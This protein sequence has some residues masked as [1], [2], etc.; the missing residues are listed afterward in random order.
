[1][2][3]KHQRKIKKINIAYYI[4]KIAPSVSQRN[5]ESNQ[6]S[7]ININ[8]KNTLNFQRNV[9]CTMNASAM[10]NSIIHNN[11]TMSRNETKL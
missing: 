8:K 2:I 1:M 9:Q 10:Q 11:D 5:L 3:E 4:V 6:E 7:Q